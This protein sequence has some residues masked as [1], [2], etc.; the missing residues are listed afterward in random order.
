MK[1]LLASI[2]SVAGCSF[3]HDPGVLAAE[4]E[5]ASSPRSSARSGVGK[6]WPLYRG[7]SLSSGVAA[8]SLPENLSPLWEFTVDGGAFESTAAIVDGVVY[9]GSTDRRVYAL[10]A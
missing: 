5:P 1:I 7:D 4:V 3:A 8:G 9:I 6:N 2:L 10:R